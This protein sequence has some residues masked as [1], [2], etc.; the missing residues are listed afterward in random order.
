[1]ANGCFPFELHVLDKAD[2][3]KY[4]YVLLND[5]VYRYKGDRWTPTCMFIA[6]ATYETDFASIPTRVLK[7][8]LEPAKFHKSRKYVSGLKHPVWIYRQIGD[9]IV[10]VGYRND[11]IAYA[12]V[13]HDYIC[14]SE[15]LSA[16]GA[17]RVFNQILK[18]EEVWTRWILFAGVQLGCWLTYFDHDPK[19]VFS[20]Y[21]LGIS[22]LKRW[23]DGDPILYPP[24]DA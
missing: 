2:G 15:A 20:D 3:S 9:K 24:T 8:I 17:N 13:I 7:K 22:A 6:P 4:P 10:L 11:P 5:F 12:A 16:W 23:A 1:M 18:E 19:E 21:R 14:S